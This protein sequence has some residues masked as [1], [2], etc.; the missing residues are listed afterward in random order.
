MK[1]LNECFIKIGRPF[2][3]RFVAGDTMEDAF[4]VAEE[5][6][7]EGLET[8]INF[9]GEEAKDKTQAWD[10]VN[11]YVAVIR[12]IHHQKLGARISVKPSQLGLKINPEFY[13]QQLR[14]VA[15]DAFV[16]DVP[17]EID[18]ETEDTTEKTIQETIHLAK[19]FSGINLRQAL[20]MNFEM[21]F[22]WLSDLAAAKIPVRLCKGAYPSKF[23][24]GKLKKRFYSAASFLLRQDASPDFATHDLKLLKRIFD[25]R[26][27][28][29][30]SCGFQ[31]LF[32]LKKTTWR[33]LAAQKERI[34]IH[35][36]F[37]ANWWPYV[38]KFKGPL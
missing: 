29:P 9:L 24:G 4:R 21:S 11:V 32:G 5:L 13:R 18:I 14:W 31:F 20:A 33:R 10:N 15:R 35:V 17:M 34:A 30:A 7:K 36:L 25:L 26:S 12:G 22:C 8:I 23:S 16:R 19:Y 28:Y 3:R 6:N 37:G 38:N 1:W 2:A 27:A